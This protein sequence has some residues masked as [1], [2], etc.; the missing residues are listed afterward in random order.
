MMNTFVNITVESDKRIMLTMP[1]FI[2]IIIALFS[3]VKLQFAKCLIILF[4]VLFAI[5][6]INF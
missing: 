2:Y 1:T 3:P 6:N 5:F 4:N